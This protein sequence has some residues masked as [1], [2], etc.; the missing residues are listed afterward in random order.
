MNRQKSPKK[1]EKSVRE[2]FR[3]NR[4]LF[5]INFLFITGAYKKFIFNDHGSSLNGFWLE[6][7]SMKNCMLI[8]K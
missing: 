2:N 7:N 6:S 4:E 3:V 8:M 1:G 5:Q